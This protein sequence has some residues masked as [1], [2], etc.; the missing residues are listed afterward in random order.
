MYVTDGSVPEKIRDKIVTDIQHKSELGSVKEKK[1]WKNK[2]DIPVDMQE[3]SK[4]DFRDKIFY[5]AMRG[6][7]IEIEERKG[8]MYM[9]AIK[10]IDRKKRRI[11]IGKSNIESK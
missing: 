3:L 9:Y 10:Y 11:Y 5:L 8:N 1:T 4:M 2:K 7:R 6:W